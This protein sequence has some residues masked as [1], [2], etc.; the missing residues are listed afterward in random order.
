MLCSIVSRDTFL[1]SFF[2][3]D[4]VDFLLLQAFVLSKGFYPFE[5][6]HKGGQALLLNPPKN[7][8][9]SRND[10]LQTTRVPTIAGASAGRRAIR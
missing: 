6:P 7:A 4:R 5:H 2:L 8:M 9:R 10:R 1:F 3:L